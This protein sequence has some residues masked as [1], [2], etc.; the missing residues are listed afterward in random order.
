MD[1]SF[2]TLGRPYSYYSE[3]IN[4]VS[5]KIP[6]LRQVHSLQL[7]SDV[8]TP[9]TTYSW[10]SASQKRA[11]RPPGTKWQDWTTL[12]LWRLFSSKVCDLTS[13]LAYVGIYAAPAFWQ[14]RGPLDWT[15]MQLETLEVLTSPTLALQ[16]GPPGLWRCRRSRT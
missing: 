5:A 8:A 16:A 10:P 3:T 9:W 6:R 11:T 7:A 15:A 2:T 13:C 4:C 14:A 12:I 1:A